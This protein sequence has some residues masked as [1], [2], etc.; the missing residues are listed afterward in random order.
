MYLASVWPG[1]GG[2]K[3]LSI[4]VCSAELAGENRAAWWN[5]TMSPGPLEF[6]MV[7]M[8][9]PSWAWAKSAIGS[10]HTPLGEEGHWIGS[11]L[12][13]W[14]V[15]ASSLLKVTVHPAFVSGVTATRLELISG[16]IWT[17]LA[18]VGQW[19]LCYVCWLSQH[20][21]LYRSL[22][23]TNE[24]FGRLKKIRSS[25]LCLLQRYF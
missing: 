9:I 11:Q 1:S 7:A 10:S 4:A 8:A 25:C 23:L 20:K 15:V 6:P 5:A 24:C 21:D 13:H 14:I 3:L 2:R 16:N 17:V 18:Y 12:G 22:L 19:E